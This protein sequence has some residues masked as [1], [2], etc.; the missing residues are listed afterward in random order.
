MGNL[1]LGIHSADFVFVGISQTS[2]LVSIPKN[3]KNYESNTA[4]RRICERSEATKYF[5]C[6]VRE[7]VQDLRESK[8]SPSLAEGDKGCG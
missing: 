7:F 2:S 8:I 1:S 3:T 6:F 4:I 5:D